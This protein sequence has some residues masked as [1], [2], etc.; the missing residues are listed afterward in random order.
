MSRAV[1]SCAQSVLLQARQS[2]ARGF[3]IGRKQKPGGPPIRRVLFGHPM[4]RSPAPGGRRLLIPQSTSSRR[5]TPRRKPAL[6]QPARP[7]WR[8]QQKHGRR[9][10]S[11]IPQDVLPWSSMASSRSTGNTEI[12]HTGS[13]A[14]LCSVLDRHRR[15]RRLRRAIRRVVDRRIWFP[16]CLA[17]R[18]GP[19]SSSSAT[20]RAG[21]CSGR[22]GALTPAG[23]QTVAMC[24]ASRRPPGLGRRA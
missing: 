10:V 21:G 6:A 2:R 22:L 17:S 20:L 19:V 12:A 23:D 9:V 11:S 15:V 14:T 13:R 18:D 16:G 4:Q 7:A 3:R 5:A 8:G 24:R 1:A